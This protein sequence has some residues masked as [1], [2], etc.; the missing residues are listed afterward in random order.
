MVA[1]AVQ[2]RAHTAAN[3]TILIVFMVFI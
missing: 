2:G 1:R 3:R